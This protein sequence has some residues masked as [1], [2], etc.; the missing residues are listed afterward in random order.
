MS[1][2]KMDLL[3]WGYIANVLLSLLKPYK[4][5]S[6][7]KLTGED[8]EIIKQSEGFLDS[9]LKGCNTIES[10]QMLSF[11][12]SSGKVPYASALSLAAEIFSTMAI[13]IPESL[14]ELKKKL[15]EY[16]N[17]LAKLR[18]S[19]E[20]A[21][22]DSLAADEVTSFFKIL[23]NKADQENYELTYSF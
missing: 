19:E 6:K 2:R 18:E 22:K 9:I 15:S 1:Q 21:K 10:P 12:N 7:L 11:S 3:F 20:F 17:V 14:E 16:R 8:I 13:P 4:K 23:G 5:G